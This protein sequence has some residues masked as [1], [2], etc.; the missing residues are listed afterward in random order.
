MKN[1]SEIALHMVFS[2]AVT[3]VILFVVTQALNMT[4]EHSVE[5]AVV[6]LQ[7]ETAS[8]APDGVTEMECRE[9]RGGEDD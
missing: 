9:F 6:L 1:L 7:C 3:L 8:P 5:K 2:A 4:T